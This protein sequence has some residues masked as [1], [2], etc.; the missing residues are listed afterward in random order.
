MERLC[1]PRHRHLHLEWRDRILRCP[2][3]ACGV[4]YGLSWLFAEYNAAHLLDNG[5]HWWELTVRLQ[6]WRLL[7]RGLIA[8]PW[9]DPPHAVT[10]QIADL[11]PQTYWPK[12]T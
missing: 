12:E 5:A 9:P 4:G 2:H 3:R 7:T 6:P 10:I 11:G 8:L 1:C